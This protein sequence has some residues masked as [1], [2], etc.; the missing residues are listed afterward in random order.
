MNIACSTCLESFTSK[1]DIS[2]TP[3]GHVFHTHC[4]EE[5]LKNGQKNCPQCRKT[6]R[7]NQI[8]KLYFSQS[9]AEDDF[10]SEVEEANLKLRQDASKANEECLKLQQENLRLKEENLKSTGE[11][12]RL[13]EHLADLKV[14]SSNIER[15]LRN[16]CAE[17]T[18]RAEKAEQ[19]VMNLK[20]QQDNLKYSNLQA[21]QESDPTSKRLSRPKK[22]PI[23]KFSPM[24][25]Q[26]RN[27]FSV[28]MLSEDWWLVY[29]MF[30]QENSEQN[31]FH[32]WRPP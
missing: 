1:S 21:L 7:Q 9:G 16:Q 32:L 13:S 20:S 30:V 28:A 8:L 17:A 15:N 29:Q 11:N 23:E 24:S 26:P 5:W 12:L 19:E 18:E 31:S 6:C 14:N 2:T 4:I 22:S 10:F 25:V 3:C 27:T